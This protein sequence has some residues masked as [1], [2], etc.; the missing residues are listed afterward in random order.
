ML[1]FAASKLSIGAAVDSSPPSPTYHDRVK[2]ILHPQRWTGIEKREQSALAH[3][4]L[5]I[6]HCT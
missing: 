2:S 4:S 5:F 3:C 1:S 6:V